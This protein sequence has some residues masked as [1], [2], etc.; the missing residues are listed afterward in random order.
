[1]LFEVHLALMDEIVVD[2]LHGH[3]SAEAMRDV[4]METRREGLLPKPHVVHKLVF[5]HRLQEILAL[6]THTSVAYHT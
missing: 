4:E 2:L 1:M 5:F 6:V 3:L